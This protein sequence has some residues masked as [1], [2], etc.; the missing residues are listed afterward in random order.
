MPASGRS[1]AGHVGRTMPTVAQLK[2]SLKKLGVSDLSGRKA[3]LE[4]RLADAQSDAQKEKAPPPV[5]S[6]PPGA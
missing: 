1:V 2:A 5:G 3:D 6:A 4:E